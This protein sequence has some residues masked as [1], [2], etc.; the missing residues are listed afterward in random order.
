MTHTM[1]PEASTPSTRTVE[2]DSTDSIHWA[3]K[4]AR[5]FTDR[6]SPAPDP[7]LADTL[8]LVVSELVTNALRHGG[9][10]FTLRLSAGPGTVTAA[11]SDPSPAPPHA[12]TPDLD[13][14]TGGFGW[15]MVRRLTQALTVTPGPGSGKTVRAQ[16]AR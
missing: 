8:V 16:F 7:A 14:A 4:A 15:H 11:V 12:R 10:R 1:I 9:G 3:R 2:G 6:L 5:T 13:G